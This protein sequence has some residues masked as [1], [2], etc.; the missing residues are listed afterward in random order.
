M[1]SKVVTYLAKSSR[2]E[3][4][5]QRTWWIV[6]PP[7]ALLVGRLTYERTC[8][9]PSRLLLA[10]TSSP[11]T[12]WPIALL[13]VVAHVWLLV[14]YVRVVARTN[15]LAPSLADLCAIEGTEVLKILLMTVVLALEY[16]PLSLWRMIGAFACTR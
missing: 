4:L 2:C 15:S 3:T 8:A 16:S 6:F 7:F 13:Y 14:V 5:P 9:D 10:L 12:A 1:P 11:T